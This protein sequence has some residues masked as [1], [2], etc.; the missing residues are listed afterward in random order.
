LWAVEPREGGVDQLPALAAD[1]VRRQVTV[2]VA[3]GIRP[4]LAV[5]AATQTI[6]VVFGTAT[7][8]V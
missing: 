2:I 5:K 4:A 8:P 3:T 1:L 6:P 7:D